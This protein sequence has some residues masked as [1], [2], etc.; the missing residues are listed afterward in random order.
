MDPTIATEIAYKNGYAA[1]RDSALKSVSVYALSNDE[2]ITRC[3]NCRKQLIFN[4]THIKH[5]TYVSKYKK[6]YL[7]VIFCPEC[8]SRIVIPTGVV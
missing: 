2:H 3:W 7:D 1:G 6:E 8:N 4:Y 5:E